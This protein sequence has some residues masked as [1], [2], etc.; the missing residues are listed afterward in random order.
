MGHLAFLGSRRVN[1]VSALHTEL[2]KQTVFKSLHSH[3]PE[4][5]VNKTNGITPRRWLMGCNPGLAALLTRP[6]ATA[7]STDLDSLAGLAPLADD[8]PFRERFAAGQAPQ[9]GAPGRARRAARLGPAS[10]PPP[11]STSRSSASTST[12]GSSSTCSTAWR[13][14]RRSASSRAP[15]GRRG[16]SCSPARPR[17]SY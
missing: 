1:G 15:P 16:S 14:G 6:S 11:C 9:Q 13:C 17:S 3:Y 4:R 10:T 7:G 5:I 12:S 8:A 2:M